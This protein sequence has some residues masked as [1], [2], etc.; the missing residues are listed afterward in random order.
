VT[1]DTDGCHVL[2]VPAGVN[3][4]PHLRDAHSGPLLTV[5]E[6]PDF[7]RDGG[8]INFVMQDGKVRF[9]INQEA[10]SR[11]QLRISSRLLRLALPPETR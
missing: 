8:I 11:A 2:F 4:A 1:R 9:E 10:A 7:L 5:G 6:S 3:A